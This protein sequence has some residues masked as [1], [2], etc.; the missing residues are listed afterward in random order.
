MTLTSILSPKLTAKSGPA[1]LIPR[2][3]TI[4]SGVQ[5][6]LDGD[7]G[8]S[9]SDDDIP[10]PAM[11]PLTRAQ[12]DPVAKFI[13]LEKEMAEAK[14]EQGTRAKE[15]LK[16]QEAEVAKLQ[17]QLAKQ[18][19]D[20]RNQIQELCA[21][22][23]VS[24]KDTS[25]GGYPA[26]KTTKVEVDKEA[27][28]RVVSCIRCI[29]MDAVQHANS[30]HAGT[31]MAMAPVAYSLWARF[32]NYN[33]EDPMWPNRDRFVLSMGHAS[34]LL[35]GLLHLAGVKEM[36]DGKVCDDEFAV[37]LEDIKQFRQLHSKCPGHPEVGHT[38][39]VECTTG[40]LGQGVATSV[41]MAMASKWQA[42]KF[43]R[44]GFENLFDFNVYALCGDGCLMEGCSAEA[45]SLAGHL[46]LDNLCW[47]WDN[48]QI[49]IEG[50]TS[51]AISDDIPTRFM[52]YGWNVLRVSD[53]N[54]FGSLSRAFNGFKKE[55]QRPTLIVVDSHI[56]WGAPTK[57]DTHEAHGGPLGVSEVAATKGV[58]NWPEEEQFLVPDEVKDTFQG[59]LARRGG[60][61]CKKWHD[62][63]LS[64]KQ[65]YPV[66]AAELEHMLNGTLPPDWD[67]FCKEFP[68]SEKGLPTRQSSSEVMNMVAQGV[69]WLL[70]GS[71][72]L[73]SSCLTNLKFSGIDHFMPPDSELGS[74]SGRIFHFG[75]REHAMGAA[76][77]GMALC[78]LRPFGSTFMAF[79]DYMKPPIRLSA[80]MKVGSIWIFTHDSIGVGEDGPTHQPTEQLVSLRTIPD[81]LT[82]R[83]CDANEVL[84]MWKY[85]LPM[86]NQPA[87]FSLSRQPLP[88]L[89]REKYAAASGLRKGAYKIAGE[90]EEP[91]LILMAS[92]SEVSLILQA[93]EQFEAEGVKVWSISMPCIELFMQQSEEYQ[94]SLLPP[95]CRARV[96]VEAA[97]R[98]SWGFFTGLDGEH[99][100]MSSFGASAPIKAVQKE[101]GFTKEG[102]IAAGKRV[103]D[104][105]PRR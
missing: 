21:Q 43:N 1:G 57:Q 51:W 54:D 31:P 71:G 93:H 104:K 48:N 18:A 26:S 5:F 92:G 29:A 36:R 25:Q 24:K 37:S 79:S 80:M 32:L 20:Y 95:T 35:Y 13:R 103:M 97:S 83:P 99:V 60:V 67:K 11:M 8:S 50:N 94:T 53:A 101:F 81:L 70:G 33:P 44:P 73:G 34:T 100:G 40:P 59:Q 68:E 96:S 91:E 39:G 4:S 88:T 105:K 64:Y 45:A 7:A 49:T 17:A 62:A 72:D 42:A 77:N 23:E 87:V 2:L 52:S 10:I 84:E 22:L 76:M 16:S 86:P 14:T 85:C 55:T 61:Q 12:T 30:G 19:A 63:L 41:G 38:T 90:A 27:D 69:P 15:A 3:P 6:K 9:S 98:E 75:I 47:I 58:Y 66:E 89:N 28:D 102:V 46:K 65:S 82:F 56:A 78:N 74:Y